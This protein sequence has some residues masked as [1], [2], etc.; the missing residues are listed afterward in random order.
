MWNFCKGNFRKVLDKICKILYNF[1]RKITFSKILKQK[2]LKKHEPK[3][4]KELH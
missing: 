4:W 2:G 1:I 3:A